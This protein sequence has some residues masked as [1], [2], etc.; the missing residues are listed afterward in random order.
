M[1]KKLSACAW[2]LVLLFVA[3]SLAHLGFARADD[4]DDDDRDHRVREFVQ[5]G[6]RV[7]GT[8]LLEITVGD[9]EFAGVCNI[10]ADGTFEVSDST[11]FG[12]GGGFLESTTYGSWRSTGARSL[13]AREAFLVF[14][15]ASGDLDGTIVVD[16]STDFDADFE[17]GVATF[18]VRL[19]PLGQDPVDPTAGVPLPPGTATLRRLGLP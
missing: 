11:D 6:L 9:F 2:L 15:P 13:V 14:D 19:V 10:H 16:I 1:N 7:A 17:T 3:G 4:D 12:G 8:Y 5:F 18:T